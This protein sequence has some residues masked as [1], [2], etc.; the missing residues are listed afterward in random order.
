MK[1]K[2]FKAIIALLILLTGS[3]V[4]STISGNQTDALSTILPAGTSVP[5]SISIQ[6]ANFSLPNGIH[7]F[8]SATNNG[9]WLLITGRTNGMHTFNPDN[10][11][12][13]SSQNSTVYVVDPVNQIVFTKSLYDATSGLSQAQIDLLSVTSAQAIQ[14]GNT[15]YITGGYGVDTAS[16]LFNTKQSLIAIDVPGLMHWVT[17]GS[18]GETAVQYIRITSHPFAQVTG[19]FM[20]QP[21]AHLPTQLVFGQNFA[22]SYDGSGTQSGNYTQQVRCFTIL[23]NGTQLSLLPRTSENPNP[24][25]RRRD[26]NVVPIIQRIGNQYQQSLLALSG[27]F[28]TQVGI[29]TVPVQIFQDGTTFMPDPTLDSTF[30]QGMN[31]YASANAGFYSP[32][33][34]NMFIT[35]LGGITYGFFQ[36]GVFE[37]DPEIPFTNEVTTIKIDSSGNF[38]QY[39]MAGQYPTILST[40]SNPGNTLLFGAAAT[41]FPVEDL[42]AYSNGVFQL[43]ALGTSPTLIGYIVGGIQSTLPNTNVATDS[44]ASPYIF[45]VILNP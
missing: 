33:S 37:V 3:E 16:G 10:N 24:N 9:K 44:A 25:Y 30:K 39:L 21:N 7:S 43:D 15:M 19:G 26:L 8:L 34:N 13:P 28:T 42:P 40:Q 11:F 14:K 1:M 29:W 27:V 18:S 12:P 35:L 2:S 4:H 45:E 41:F 36:N 17:N 5:F 23:D 22:I 32:K 6:Q 31:N 38:Q 20:Y